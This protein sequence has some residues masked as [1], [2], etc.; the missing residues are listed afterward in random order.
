MKHADEAIARGDHYAAAIEYLNVLQ[1]NRKHSEAL[2]NLANIAKPA[3][4]QK[5]RMAEA[6]Q[7]QRNFEASLVEYK[8]LQTY[9]SRL[10]MFN[11]L[12]FIPIDVGQVIHK[13]SLAAAEKH[14]LQAEVFFSQR[15]FTRAISEYRIALDFAGVYKDSTEK[16]AESYYRMAGDFEK[17][18]NYR[19]AAKTYEN[20]HA[21]IR[22]YK[23]SL[24]K[25]TGLYYALGSYF[26]SIGQYRKAYED[27][28][29]AQALNP[30][31]RDVSQK[32]ATAGD[33]AIIKIALVSFD[34]PT[35]RDVAG[36]VLGDYIFSAI[37]S[38]V[39]AKAS[40]F[41]QLLERE[42]FLTLARTQKIN[43]N[44]L[45]DEG[46]IPIK[47]TGVHYL[48]FGR[49]TQVRNTRAGLTETQVKDSYQ[50]SY[51][52]AYV[53]SKG[54]QAKRKEW[55]S[56]PMYYSIFKDKSAVALAGTV[57]VVEVK[58][59]RT[60]I[61]FPFSEKTGDEIVYADKFQAKHDLNADNIRVSDEIRRLS[62][63]RR[64]L[65]DEELF[66]GELIKIIAAPVAQRILTDLDT[67]PVTMD[68]TQLTY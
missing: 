38:D 55:V 5:L 64:E 61:E 26:L 54:Q 32:W 39:Q 2:T 34:N 8:D 42:D 45:N 22:D 1:I 48:V 43:E 46:R 62:G 6:Y 23:N 35:G 9:L 50:Y 21:V 20:A 68:P 25:A 57:K 59:G 31:Y 17:N 47:L 7:A 53:D 30:Q 37:K 67:A 40:A 3:Y 13:V 66:A 4:E 14:Y 36:M 63:A 11:L 44:L 24:T 49:F 60:V 29:Q 12:H 18:R 19:S 10:K 65:R 58:S 28:G 27:L 51:D 33:K 52:V 16:I 15:D 41:V 56:A